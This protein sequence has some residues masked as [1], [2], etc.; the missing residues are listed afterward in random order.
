MR[1][2]FSGRFGVIKKK[3]MIISWFMFTIHTNNK[4]GCSGKAT[5]AFH[6]RTQFDSLL[7]YMWR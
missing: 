7:E 1:E 2:I 4:T 6:R 3:I 5:E